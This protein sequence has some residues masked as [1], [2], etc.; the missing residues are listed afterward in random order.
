MISRLVRPSVLPSQVLLRRNRHVDDRSI[1][2]PARVRERQHVA[3]PPDNAPQGHEDDPKRQPPRGK[4]CLHRRRPRLVESPGGADHRPS[5]DPHHAVMAAG[6][7]HLDF[8]DRVLSIRSRSGRRSDDW[9]QLE[10]LGDGPAELE[11]SDG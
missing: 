10:R 9:G 3:S 2:R 11:V 6:L 1:G 7:D 5:V 4:A 8:T